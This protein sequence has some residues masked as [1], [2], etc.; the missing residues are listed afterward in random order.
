[1]PG[2]SVSHTSVPEV[3]AVEAA[4]ENSEP[5]TVGLEEEAFLLDAAT[6]RPAAAA[7]DVLARL[8]D[9]GRFHPELPASQ[10]EIAT[11]P[12]RHVAAAVTELQAARRELLTACG[13]GVRPIV[14]G[15]FPLRAE[16]ELSERPEYAWLRHEYASVA[17]RQ[18]VASLQVH[19]AVGGAQRTLAVHDALRSYLPEIAALAA[20]APF[21]NGLDTGLASV[22]PTLAEALPRQGVPPAL[23]SW[24]RYVDGLE[25]AAR[26]GAFDGA[27]YW[28]WELRPHPAFGTLEVRVPDAQSRVGEAAAVAAFVQA[29]VATLADRHDAGGPLPVHETWRIEE[30]RWAAARYGIEGELRDLDTGE[31]W[32]ARERLRS[33]L[34]MCRPAAARLGAADALARAEG[35]IAAN[36]AVRQRGIAAERGIDAIPAWLAEA[37]GSESRQAGIGLV[38]DPAGG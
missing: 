13:D 12:H 30:N 38:S 11:R 8:D 17:R 26:S 25:W 16:A 24:H 28:W 5:F 15:V 21:L 31:R 1:M 32:R 22:R 7:D 18:L 14:A 27:R 36:G 23:G 19:V 37:Y 33:L 10:L 2:A 35:L 9:P 3:A 34:E 4:F 6:L 29:L 20:N